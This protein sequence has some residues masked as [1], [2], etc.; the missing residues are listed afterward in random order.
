MSPLEIKNCKIIEEIQL[1]NW[2]VV[3]CFER[4]AVAHVTPTSEAGC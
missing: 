2:N 1:F 4:T 3:C